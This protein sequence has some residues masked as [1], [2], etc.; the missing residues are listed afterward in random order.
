MRNFLEEV[1]KQ[2]L[3]LSTAAFGFVAALVWKDAITAW[4]SPL[5]EDASDATGLTL[6]AIVVTVIV[7]M[8]TIVLAKIFK[9]YEKGKKP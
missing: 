7:V 3:T 4:L 8:V 9:P 5:Y 2:M 6:A 1:K